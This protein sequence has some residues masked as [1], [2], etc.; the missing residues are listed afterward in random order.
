MTKIDRGMHNSLADSLRQNSG[1]PSGPGDLVGFSGFSM[2]NTMAGGMG[3][4]VS[5]ELQLS[6]WYWGIDVQSSSVKTPVKKSLNMRLLS[7]SESTKE[8]SSRLSELLDGR[9]FRRELTY[10][11]NCLTLVVL[12][13]AKLVS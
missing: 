2:S 3:I 11:Q 5:T 8:L 7:W 1:Q 13:D 4:S 9:V 12:L 10:F 6:S